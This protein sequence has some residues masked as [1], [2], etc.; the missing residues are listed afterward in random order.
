M[1]NASRM[2]ISCKDDDRWHRLSGDGYERWSFNAISDDGRDIICISFY[3]HCPI[4]PRYYTERNVRVPLVEFTCT[5]GNE[6]V[7]STLTEFSPNSFTEIT[8]GRGY[9]IGKNSFQI[10]EIEYGTGHIIYLTLTTPNGQ[11]IS[12]ELE[13]IS[14]NEGNSESADTG[15]TVVNIVAPRADVSGRVLIHGERRKELHFRGTGWHAH[16]IISGGAKKEATQFTGNVHFADSTVFVKSVNTSAM[17]L[18]KD[19]EFKEVPLTN[20]RIV[21]QRNRFGMRYPKEVV[22]TGARI[23]S[24]KISPIM[25]ITSTVATV[26]SKAEYQLD[27]NDGKIRRSIGLTFFTSPKRMRHS[28]F[29]YVSGLGIVVAPR[30][31]EPLFQE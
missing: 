3:D 1:T 7:V 16:E 18:I 22:Y 29:R 10:R 15:E 2:F 21:W 30:G 12:A 6:R 17:L 27:L 31:I 13:W 19:G 14:I 25:T 20:S 9:S 24:L 28:L 11:R 4:S 23:G 26:R 8:D 5:A